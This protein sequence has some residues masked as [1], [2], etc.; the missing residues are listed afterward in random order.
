MFFWCRNVS[1]ALL[2]SECTHDCC[3]INSWVYLYFSDVSQISK[4]FPV[5][6]MVFGNGHKLSLSPENYLF[7]VSYVIKSL[8]S[9]VV[10]LGW[11]IFLSLFFMWLSFMKHSKVRGAYC[12]GVFSNGN[13]PTT[14]LGGISYLVWVISCH[15]IL[16][17][18]W[19][20]VPLWFL[21]ELWVCA[22]L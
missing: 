21:L 18:F 10:F 5:V 1:L 11:S 8:L 15:F 3:L 2:R 6:E 14:L 4:S 20:I 19:N 17:L 9:L 7:R 22:I 16:S 12:L 13:D